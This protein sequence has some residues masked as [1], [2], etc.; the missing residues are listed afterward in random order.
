MRMLQAASS[1][2]ESLVFNS[3]PVFL[4]RQNIEKTENLSLKITVS[5]SLNPTEQFP[6]CNLFFPVQSS[7]TKANTL[8]CSQ[9]NHPPIF[10]PKSDLVPMEHSCNVQ[11]S[12][13][14][15]CSALKTRNDHKS[16]KV[17]V[18]WMLYKSEIVFSNKIIP[19]S[20]SRLLFILD[21]DRATKPLYQFFL[22]PFSKYNHQPYHQSLDKSCHTHRLSVTFFFFFSFIGFTL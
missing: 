2:H 1:L 14:T 16:M 6:N 7:M 3:F 9:I 21:G 13:C 17:I 20:Q 22:S 10:I 8:H 19:K 11:F 15:Y 4:P 18:A 12:P 5:Q